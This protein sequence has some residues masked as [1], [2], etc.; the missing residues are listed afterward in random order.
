MQV[1]ACSTSFCPLATV[2]M[3]SVDGIVVK[4]ESHVFQHPVF[5]QSEILNSCIIMRAGCA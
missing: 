4:V 2:A 5:L 1:K 3:C